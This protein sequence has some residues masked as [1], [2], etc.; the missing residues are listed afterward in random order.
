[1]V[2]MGAVALAGAVAFLAACPPARIHS[3]RPSIVVITID[4]MRADRLSCYG[5]FR[6]TSPQID[7]FAAGAVRFADALT[8]MATTLPAHISLFT[9]TLP[10][11]HGI[12][13]NFEQLDRKFDSGSGIPTLAELLS[14]DGYATAAFVSATPVKRSSGI[15]AGFA[16]FDEPE[17]KERDATTTTD[18]VLAWLASPPR[19]PFFLW[20]HYFDPHEPYAPPERFRIFHDEPALTDLL[21]KLAVPDPNDRTVREAN[22]LYD[23]EVLHVDEQVGRLLQ[24]L[25]AAEVY[26]NAAIVLAGDHGEGLGQHGWMGHGHIYN[27]Q[28]FVPLVVKLPAA[29]GVAPGVRTGLTSLIDVLPTL[30]DHGLVTLAPEARAR[31]EGVD[32][33]ADHPDRHLLAE[34][35][36]RERNWEPGL[37]YAL[38]GERW[39]FVHRI[40]KEGGGD[41]DELYEMATDRPEIHNVI[42][43]HADVAKTMRERLLEELAALG[44][45]ARGRAG[46][47]VPE[48]VIEEL[49]SLGYV[50]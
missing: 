20:V 24:A 46:D 22:N 35:V 43:E 14:A 34:R 33:L 13:G 21:T 18:K 16:A 48:E 27:E 28:L 1:M 10:L 47:E 44:S 11:Q 37:K 26:D 31:L 8:P 2:A 7:A 40:G 23:G 49:K 38:I 17:G 50:K 32:A 29:A 41:A 15:D 45:R 25:R 4:T 9:S 5:H 6:K 36:N 30:A 39:K 42:A 19:E 3:P 12:K